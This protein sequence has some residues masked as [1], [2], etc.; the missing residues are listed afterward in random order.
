MK[1]FLLG[2]LIIVVLLA[3][4]LILTLNKT[5]NNMTIQLIREE[6]NI[7]IN[8]KD[9][10]YITSDGV[11]IFNINQEN[12]TININGEQLTRIKG[13]IMDS[14]L[15][16][17]EI[18][19]FKPVHLPD[20]FVR[21]TLIINLDNKTKS[22][23]WVEYESNEFSPSIVPPLLLHLKDMIYCLSNVNEYYNIKCS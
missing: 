5:K 1:T 23:K 19:E 3:I 7:S 16:N 13:Y 11:G 20:R 6:V 15:L 21:Y 8:K 22:F 14:G 2:S 12:R 9:T 4:F 17:M 10:L 18:N